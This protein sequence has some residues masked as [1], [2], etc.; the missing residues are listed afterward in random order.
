MCIHNNQADLSLK[1]FH[2]GD[3]NDDGAVQLTDGVIVLNWLFKGGE[4]PSCVEAADADDN[5]AVNLTDAIYILQYL[6]LG[7][8]PPPSPGPPGTGPCGPD[9]QGALGCVTYTSC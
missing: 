2:R 6:F 7:G 4:V 5:G 1:V 8:A 3:V 9:D